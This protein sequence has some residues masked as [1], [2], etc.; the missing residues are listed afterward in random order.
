[1]HPCQL[2]NVPQHRSLVVCQHCQP[3][4]HLTLGH[5]L[6]GEIQVDLM[7]TRF[8]GQ[9]PAVESGELF[10]L[11]GVSE[12]LEALTATRLDEGVGSRRPEEVPS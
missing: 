2:R 4:T 3:R 8:T 6:R 1:M 11:Y 12:D 7:V 9:K 10:V 5:K